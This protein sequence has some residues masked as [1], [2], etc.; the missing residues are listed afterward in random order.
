MSS[1]VETSIRNFFSGA[2]IQV[3]GGNPKD[4]KVNNRDFYHKVYKNGIVGFGESYMDGDW[5][6]DDMPELFRTLALTGRKKKRNYIFKT[7]HRARNY[8]F[9][10]QNRY[11]SMEVT[12]HY[13]LG[14]E[15]WEEIKN[16]LSFDERFKRMWNYYLCSNAGSFRAR[17]I[18]LWQIIFTKH[19][20]GKVYD[21]SKIYNMRGAEHD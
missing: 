14:N 11:R 2:G 13:N 4:I 1:V 17:N 18:Q 9:N 5:E 19:K 16:T 8:L 20:T 7:I 3:N 21:R 10:L 6:C 12:K 15:M